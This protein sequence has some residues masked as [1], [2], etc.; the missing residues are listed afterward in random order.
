MNIRFTLQSN[1]GHPESERS[2]LR[3]QLRFPI[4]SVGEESAC[5]AGDPA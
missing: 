5:N 4:G 3:L 1:V 2:M